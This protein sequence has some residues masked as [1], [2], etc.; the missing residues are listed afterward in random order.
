MNEQRGLLIAIEGGDG[1]GKA[2]QAELTRTYIANSLG[3][4]VLKEAF[5]RY[6]KE[7]ARYVERYLNGDYGNDVNSL[8]AEVAAMLFAVD[9]MAGTPDIRKWL[10][11]NPTG[12]AVLDRY[13][14]SNLAHQGAKID[15]AGTRHAFYEELQSYEA[16]VLN[17]LPTDKN[18]VLLVPSAVAQHNVDQKDVRGYT[19]KKRDIHESDAV[20]LEKVKACYEELC[21]LYPEHYIPITC[22]NE[23]G[24]MRSRDA[25]QQ[26]I[27]QV[28]GI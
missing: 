8:P 22:T 13:M 6:G 25:I 27:R 2:T 23:Q 21:E 4:S 7:S 16:N 9:R 12:I 11:E 15:N 14:G 10:E 28:I 18:I 5:P 20:Y 17:M 19:D 1:S 26:D 24:N 3:R